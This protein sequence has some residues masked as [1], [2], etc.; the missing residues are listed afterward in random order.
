MRASLVLLF[1]YEILLKRGL[2]W[3]PST[4]TYLG[5][6]YVTH[7]Q[8]AEPTQLLGCVE[9]HRR[10]PGGHLGVETDLDTGLDLVL[11]FDQQIQQLLSI[12]DSLS[13]V[14]H[15]TDQ[16]SV[17]FVYNLLTVELMEETHEQQT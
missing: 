7:G 8:H 10:E 12:D 11:T 17:P 4:I 13:E 3:I 1:S 2:Q 9:D 5:D 15:Q 6:E 16:S 14:C